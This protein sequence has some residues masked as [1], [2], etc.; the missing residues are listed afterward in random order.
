M[1]TKAAGRGFSEAER[2]PAAVALAKASTESKMVTATSAR[3]KLSTPLA[4]CDGPGSR[5][6]FAQSRAQGGRREKLDRPLDA[7]GG[8]P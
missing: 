3:A 2:E 6:G 5:Q 8:I 1:A 4:C 7:K